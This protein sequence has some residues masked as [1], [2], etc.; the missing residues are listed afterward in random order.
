MKTSK[1]WADKYAK[2]PK[3]YSEFLEGYLKWLDELEMKLED[4]YEII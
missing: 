4:C 1:K 2:F 3:E